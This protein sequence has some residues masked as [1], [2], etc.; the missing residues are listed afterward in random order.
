MLDWK[1]EDIGE[2]AKALAQV[3]GDIGAAKKDADNPFFKSKYADLP[4]VWDACREVLSKNGLAVSQLNTPAADGLLAVRTVLLHSSG[5]WLASVI[6]LPAKKADPQAYGSAITYARRYALACIVGV[7]AD[8][9]DD[10][11]R[12]MVRGGQPAPDV[13]AQIAGTQS[14]QDLLALWNSQAKAWEGRSDFKQI[15]DAVKAKQREFQQ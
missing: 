8:E 11:E 5:Q 13:F 6:E 12:A 10:A 14:A 7:V 9:D 3:Q 1:S 2:L 4:A 15:Q